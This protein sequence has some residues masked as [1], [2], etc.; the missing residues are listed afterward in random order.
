MFTTIRAALANDNALSSETLRLLS[1]VFLLL[2]GV[3]SFFK[4]TQIGTFWDT[5][6]TFT[7][8]FASTLMAIA[9]LA[10]LYLR[11]ILK[12][13][14]SAFS[15]LSFVLI[16]L[17]FASFIELALGGN[18]TGGL[19]AVILA[20][21][22]VLSWLGIQAVAGIAWLLVLGAGIYSA[23]MNHMAMGFFGFIYIAAGF[24]GL[25][26]HSGLSPGELNRA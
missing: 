4:Y 14:G 22:V 16:L 20:V 24:L 19:V 8:G 21:A 18:Q 13:N 10:P 25:T 23:V 2:S 12:W 3:M 26:L 7:P 6:L 15:I 17:V 1:L 5:Q 9:M 11:G